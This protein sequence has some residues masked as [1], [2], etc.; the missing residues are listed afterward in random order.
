MGGI[1]ITFVLLDSFAWSQCG[2]VAELE[3]PSVVFAICAIAWEQLQ[4][5]EIDL[6]FV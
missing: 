6:A 5:L 1:I 2:V 3:F 4:R